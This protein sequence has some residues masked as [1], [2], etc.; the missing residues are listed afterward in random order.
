MATSDGVGSVPPASLLPDSLRQ[1]IILGG[2]SERG[3]VYASSVALSPFLRQTQSVLLVDAVDP[4]AC[5]ATAP[6]FISGA[7]LQRANDGGTTLQRIREALRRSRQPPT[8]STAAS[9][10][11]QYFMGNVRPAGEKEVLDMLQRVRLHPPTSPVYTL[12]PAEDILLV[13]LDSTTGEVG[14]LTDALARALPGMGSQ[15]KILVIADHAAQ[16]VLRQRLPALVETPRLAS[17]PMVVLVQVRALAPPA[18]EYALTEVAIHSRL[19]LRSMLASVCA[20]AATGCINELPVRRFDKV[21]VVPVDLA[22]NTALMALCRDMSESSGASVSPSRCITI[23]MNPSPTEGLVWGMVEVYIVDYYG[24]YIKAITEAFP[25]EGIVSPAPSVDFIYNPN[26]VVTWGPDSMGMPTVYMQHKSHQ[27]RKLLWSRLPPTAALTEMLRSID[28]VCTQ[29]KAQSIPATPSPYL[30]SLNLRVPW[31]SPHEPIKTRDDGS[32][33]Y[34]D[35]INLYASYAQ[36]RDLVQLID[37]KKIDWDIYV[38]LVQKN[39]LEHIACR[40]AHVEDFHFPMPTR[41]YANSLAFSSSCQVPP[42]PSRK[43]QLFPT[44]D[45]VCHVGL[46]PNG[47]R[48]SM[49]PGMTPETMEVVLSEPHIQKMV[50]SV[51][52]LDKQSKEEVLKRCRRI[53][54]RIGDRLNHT[55]CRILGTIVQNFFQRIYDQICISAN[56]HEFLWRLSMTPRVEVVYIPLHRSYSD[57]LTISFLLM[58]MGIQLPHIVAGEDFLRMGKFAEL[59]RGSGAFFMRR[60]FRDDP[61][62][63]TLFREYVRQLVW[64][65]LPIE[66]FIEGTRSRTGKTLAPKLGILKFITDAFFDS[67]CKLDDVLFVPV[68]LSYDEPLEAKIYADELLGIPKPKESIPNAIKA[69]TQLKHKYGN[70]HLHFGDPIS[71]CRFKENPSQCPAP[72][73]TPAAI[74]EAAHKVEVPPRCGQGADL[75]STPPHILTAL[76][77]RITYDLQRNIHLSAS[78]L[79]AAIVECF[80]P[81]L[82]KSGSGPL[83][84]EFL[85]DHMHWLLQAVQVRGGHLTPQLNAIVPSRCDRTSPDRSALERTTRSA[86][87]YLQ[88]FVRLDEQQQT[89]AFDPPAISSH[90]G[91]NITTNQLIHLFVDE[92]V[93]ATVA[94]A[95]GTPL[96][97]AGS[98][99][100]Y[101]IKKSELESVTLFLY[102]LLAPE[103]PNFSKASPCRFHSWLHCTLTRMHAGV[104]ERA[105]LDHPDIAK[106]QGRG[107][108][109]VPATGL[110]SFVVQLISPHMEAL[111]MVAASVLA[112]FEAQPED[113]IHAKAAVNACHK[114]ALAVLKEHVIESPISCNKESIQ[115]YYRSLLNAGFLTVASSTPRAR[116]SY[117][118]GPRNRQGSHEELRGLLKKLNSL[119]GRE[120]AEEA[121]S[122]VRVRRAVVSTYSAECNRA[123]M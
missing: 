75:G 42:N 72:Y 49:E 15:G 88:R 36:T 40:I 3:A 111:Y 80:T 87:H 6:D 113:L 34:D 46:S 70:I 53:M 56:T 100:A 90:L 116:I 43:R 10:P 26:D 67:S 63:G 121:D 106:H 64:R 32:E 68:S 13:V 86:L 76:G 21:P 84:F 20:G 8:V 27:R 61:L 62:Y 108:V 48:A 66:F 23:T 44:A 83:T 12:N 55:H 22:L 30:A 79:V 58:V 51:C 95:F 31:C 69:A 77:W 54:E 38:R 45:W 112:L 103:F 114:A 96:V 91:L 41:R 104:Q 81:I 24:R 33:K 98:T 60:S 57:F 102:A 99:L 16:A 89:V 110:F 82:Q 73:Q 123:K 7:T 2:L 92:G 78:A 1:I 50:D 35:L 122:Y 71:L 107:V 97:S 9:I 37:L 85:V 65:C 39:V 109:I 59:M 93:V 4:S 74:Q 115:N 94:R 11:P 17:S 25:V 19:G 52:R 101:V 120:A 18:L 5:P 118:R 119:R 28:D 105:A 29:V 14:P 117:Q 47:L